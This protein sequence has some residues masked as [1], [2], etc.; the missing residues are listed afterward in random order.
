MGPGHPDAGPHAAFWHG[1]WLSLH[2]GQGA[3]T[4]AFTLR[5]ERVLRQTVRRATGHLGTVSSSPS[6]TSDSWA[7]VS[8]PY[9]AGIEQR[10]P[11][12]FGVNTEDPRQGSFR[13]TSSVTARG[14][15]APRPQR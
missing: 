5:H 4:S 15:M 11:V 14:E 10:L 9:L 7:L 12:A 3:S 1:F 2:A 6:T 8:A 13:D